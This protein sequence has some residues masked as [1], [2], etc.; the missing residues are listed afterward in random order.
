MAITALAFSGYK[1]Y[2]VMLTPM[3]IGLLFL[4]ALILLAYS[5]KETT[6]NVCQIPLL[7]GNGLT[8]QDTQ[9]SLP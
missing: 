8:K 6:H 1:I 2:I 5:K 4:Q 7:K 9:N 3:Y